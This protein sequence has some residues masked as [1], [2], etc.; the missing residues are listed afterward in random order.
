MRAKTMKAMMSLKLRKILKDPVK[1]KQLQKAL[2][3]RIKS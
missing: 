2:T 1:A 3:K